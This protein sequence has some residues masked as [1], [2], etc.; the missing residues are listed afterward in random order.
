MGSSHQPANLSVS[1]TSR[2]EEI[3]MTNPFEN[4]NKIRENMRADS[5][6]LWE[7]YEE[8]FRKLSAFNSEKMFNSRNSFLASTFENEY[9]TS[10][11]SS[12]QVQDNKVEVCLDVSQY[13]PEELEVKVKDNVVTVLGRQET[14]SGTGNTNTRAARVFTKSFTLPHRVHPAEVESRLTQDGRLVITAPA[15]KLPAK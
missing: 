8:E 9:P 13:E 14:G 15:R 2:M 3:F 4:Y 10:N 7:K 11:S 12:M 5:S 6:K 1:S